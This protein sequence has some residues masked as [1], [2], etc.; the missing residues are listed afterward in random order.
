[1]WACSKR[2]R[3]IRRI[4]W[5]WVLLRKFR[6]GR[7]RMK[8]REIK[9]RSRLFA[10]KTILRINPTWCI[11]PR[12]SALRTWFRE[13]NS[14]YPQAES[15][16]CAKSATWLPSNALLARTKTVSQEVNLIW[17]RSFWIT[18]QNSKTS[19]NNKTAITHTQ[20][21]LCA[22]ILGW[23]ACS[24]KTR[25]R[26]LIWPVTWHTSWVM[27]RWVAPQKKSRKERLF[28]ARCINKMWRLL[29]RC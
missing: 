12:Q 3:G 22:P 7:N 21:R 18:V 9:L 2:T 29:D 27:I 6:R 20:A 19:P 11:K 8:D 10:K 23:T 4:V 17:T 26:R 24:P 1:M 14:R 15:S 5:V 13:R 16:A 25:L 28:S